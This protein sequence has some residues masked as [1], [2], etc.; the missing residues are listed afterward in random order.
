LWAAAVLLA[1]AGLV[2]TLAVHAMLFGLLQVAA[3]LRGARAGLGTARAQA[4]P[5]GS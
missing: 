5:P 1:I 4:G 3:R 2:L